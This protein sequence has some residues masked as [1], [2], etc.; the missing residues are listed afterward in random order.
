[1]NSKEK[2]IIDRVSAIAIEG[3]ETI[4][5]LQKQVTRIAKSNFEISCFLESTKQTS[6]AS[7]CFPGKFEAVMDGL[8][9]LSNISTQSLMAI[10]QIKS[11]AKEIQDILDQEELV[12]K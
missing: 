1:M 5:L 2:R 10:D 12:E 11:H 6:A 8:Q 7:P 9:A 3:A 4:Y